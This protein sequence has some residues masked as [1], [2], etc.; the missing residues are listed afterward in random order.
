MFEG[1]NFAQGLAKKGLL[2]L[3]YLGSQYVTGGRGVRD[4]MPLEEDYRTLLPA[5]RT[6]PPETVDPK[7]LDGVLHVDKLTGVYLSKTIHREDQPSH[8]MVHDRELCVR[9]C[10]PTYGS[11][12]T[13]FCPGNV[14][15]MAAD[16]ETGE[17]QLK[18]NPSNCFH[19]KTCDIKDPYENI[20][21]TCPE[22]G[23]GPGYTIV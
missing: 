23:E 15:E 18:L 19:C 20:T 14:Y 11:P 17:M 22:G 8:L 7:S 16:E 5:E 1:R 6:T 3:I 12:C 21:W 9:V 2:K 4:F 10:Y 13:R